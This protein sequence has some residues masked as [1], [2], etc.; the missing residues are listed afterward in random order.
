MLPKHMEHVLFGKILDPYE[1]EHAASMIIE[2]GN[3][4]KLSAMT[5]KDYSTA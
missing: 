2:L 5:R 1:L 4:C 3:V